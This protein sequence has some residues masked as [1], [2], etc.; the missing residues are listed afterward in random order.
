MYQCKILPLYLPSLNYFPFPW[1]KMQKVAEFIFDGIIHILNSLELGELSRCFH[2]DFLFGFSCW[3][4]CW[5]MLESRMSWVV[6]L[7]SS[8]YPGITAEKIFPA[9]LR[10]ILGFELAGVTECTMGLGRSWAWQAFQI[11]LTSIIGSYVC[12]RLSW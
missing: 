9:I 4:T 11:F 10:K 6:F 7:T 12:N 1:V 8:R 5:K 2:A 3:K